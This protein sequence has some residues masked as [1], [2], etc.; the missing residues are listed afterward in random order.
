MVTKESLELL[1]KQLQNLV[2]TAQPL[3][4]LVLKSNDEN[5]ITANGDEKQGEV[6]SAIFKEKSDVKAIMLIN[7]EYTM[8]T[9]QKLTVLK[10]S[11]DDMA[12][13]VGI[14]AKIAND[15]TENTIL[16]CL[17]KRNAC[18]VKG[19]GMLVTGR[20]SKEALTTAVLLEKACRTEIL[21]E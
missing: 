9:A 17:K 16:N 8:L 4:V 12:Q 10:A 14:T 1:E 6:F 18:L 3:P 21:G 20:S 5:C 7:T 13:I 2:P 11:L 15:F 19:K